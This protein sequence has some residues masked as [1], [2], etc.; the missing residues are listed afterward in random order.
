MILISREKY[1][2]V[3]ASFTPHAHAPLPPK[4]S[5]KKIIATNGEWCIDIWINAPLMATIFFLED[6]VLLY[7]IPFKSISFEDE[8]QLFVGRI[9]KSC[10]KRFIILIFTTYVQPINVWT[11]FSWHMCKEHESKPMS[12]RSTKR[13]CLRQ[14]WN[15]EIM[16]LDL[17]KVFLQLL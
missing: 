3:L 4:K 6:H 13:I 9:S 8:L 17:F 14:T 7:S 10:S 12:N 2:S 15:K 1:L 16:K 5:L 11:T